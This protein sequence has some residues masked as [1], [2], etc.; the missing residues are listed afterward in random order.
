MRICVNLAKQATKNGDFPFGSIVVLDNE[1]V[2]RGYNT[3]IAKKEVCLHA[4]ILALIHAQKRLSRKKLSQC[5]IYSTVEPCPMCSF[6]IR[7]LNIRR[8]VFGLRSPFMGGYSRWKILQDKK[9]NKI[10]PEIFL[11]VPKIIPD[12]FKEGVVKGW[13]NWNK[14]SWDDFCEKGLFG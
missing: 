14:K 13:E 2:G 1:I 11:E 4:E 9:L 10:L 5:T 8:V 6:A 3:A 12:V 7:E